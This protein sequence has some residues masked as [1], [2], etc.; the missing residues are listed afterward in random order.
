[1]Y[2]SRDAQA[3]TVYGI[4]ISLK[5]CSLNTSALA[6]NTG[7]AMSR[8]EIRNQDCNNVVSY[9]GV[10]PLCTPFHHVPHRPARGP[11]PAAPLRLLLRP[12]PGQDGAAAL[13]HRQGEEHQGRV[14]ERGGPGLQRVEG[15]AREEGRGG[16]ANPT[17]AQERHG[18]YLPL[19]GKRCNLCPHSAGSGVCSQPHQVLFFVLESL[20]F[21]NAQ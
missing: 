21:L 18:E 6:K 16:R 11:R 9:V 5:N 19:L 4:T 2:A 1:M 12:P 8:P 7:L 13:P 15:E 10:A 17:G 14:R 3:E 20:L